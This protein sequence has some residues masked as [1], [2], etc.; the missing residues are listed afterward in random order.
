MQAPLSKFQEVLEK[1]PKAASHRD[2]ENRTPLHFACVQ[3]L[4][5]EYIKPLVEA[6]PDALGVKNSYGNYPYTIAKKFK[7]ASQELLDL[8]KHPDALD[9]EA[10]PPPGF[11]F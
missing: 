11:D 8:L 9:L 2:R 10:N 5:I 1:D 6:N 7:D 3:R 4:A